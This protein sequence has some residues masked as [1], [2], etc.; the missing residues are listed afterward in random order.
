ME[1]YREKLEKLPPERLIQLVKVYQNT[2]KGL[3]EQ[4]DQ[5]TMVA[6]ITVADYTKTQLDQKKAELAQIQELLK[7]HQT[8]K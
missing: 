8:D 5:A 6:M 3:Q 7:Q 1:D 2:I 4:Y